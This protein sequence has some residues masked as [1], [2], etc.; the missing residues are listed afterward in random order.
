MRQALCNLKDGDYWVYGPAEYE[1]EFVV[2]LMQKYSEY[3]DS[4]VSSQVA[5]L[6][7]EGEFA[8]ATN[9]IS[10]DLAYYSH[11]EKGLLWS[12]ALWRIQG[13]FE[14]LIVW[15]YLPSRPAKP[16]VGL[17]SK[18]QALL[19]HGYTLSPAHRS[20]LEAWAN[21]RNLLSHA[22]PEHFSPIA[23]DREDIE[24]YVSLLRAVCSQWSKERAVLFPT[25]P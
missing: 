4:V 22:P 14:A 17:Q 19:R 15:R 21:L 3:A 1:F 11:I 9:E 12:F 2:E 8:D 24:E 6:P 16:L 13:I 20:D 25:D 5:E 18:L 23:V 10:S 7:T